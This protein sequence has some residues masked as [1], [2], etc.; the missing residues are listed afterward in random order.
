[1]I[2]LMFYHGLNVGKYN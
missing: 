2:A 1:M